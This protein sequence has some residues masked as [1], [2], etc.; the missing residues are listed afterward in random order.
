MANERCGYTR[1]WRNLIYKFCQSNYDANFY[2]GGLYCDN[3]V[4]ECVQNLNLLT[5]HRNNYSDYDFGYF[6]EGW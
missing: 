1:N 2:E 3:G 5:I 6:W 4:G